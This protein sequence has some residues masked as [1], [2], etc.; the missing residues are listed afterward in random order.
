MNHLIYFILLV[1]ARGFEPPTSCSQSRRAARLRHA[2]MMCSDDVKFLGTMVF[3]SMQAYNVGYRFFSKKSSTPFRIL[4]TIFDNTLVSFN[5]FSSTGLVIYPISRHTAGIS[6][7][8]R[9]F[10]GAPKI[11]PFLNKVCSVI[12]FSNKLARILLDV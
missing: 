8:S 9:T 11:S 5:D 4:W 3:F 1:G 6:A 2:P 12:R 10:S 7:P